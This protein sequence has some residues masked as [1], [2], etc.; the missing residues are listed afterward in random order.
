[1]QTR[2]DYENGRFLNFKEYV[3]S[4]GFHLSSIEEA[5]SFNNYHETIHLGF[6]IN[7]KKFNS[8]VC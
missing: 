4:I 3:T 8:K 6:M 7:M 2:D 1:M 5:I